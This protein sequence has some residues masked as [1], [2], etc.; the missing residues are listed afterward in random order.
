[1]VGLPHLRLLGD[2]MKRTLTLK[3]ETLAELTPGE[4]TSVVGGAR[5]TVAPQATCP[6]L[7]CLGTEPTHG[8]AGSCS[9]CTA[10]A[11]C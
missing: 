8:G 11:S 6:L 1:V 2:A 10:S 5:Y 7:W 9:C 4:L 3:R